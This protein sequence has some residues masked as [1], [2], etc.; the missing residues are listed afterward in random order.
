MPEVQFRTYVQFQ[1]CVFF[2]FCKLCLENLIDS[3]CILQWNRIFEEVH[4][5]WLLS[6]EQFKFWTYWDHRSSKESVV[7]VMLFFPRRPQLWSGTDWL[8]GSYFERYKRRAWLLFFF[9][10]FNFRRPKLWTGT[11]SYVTHAE[12]GSSQSVRLYS[13]HSVF[14]IG[15]THWS[16]PARQPKKQQCSKLISFQRC[17]KALLRTCFFFLN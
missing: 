3:S 7:S 9:F 12:K 8:T 4:L 5:W 13:L 17:L 11:S 15:C 1:I 2:F 16:E 10:N 6:L 14:R